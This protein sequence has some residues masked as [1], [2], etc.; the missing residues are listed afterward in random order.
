MSDEEFDSF[1]DDLADVIPDAL[2]TDTYLSQLEELKL[3]TSKENAK[4]YYVFEW[5]VIQEG[6]YEG[7]TFSEMYRKATLEEYQKAEK[8]EQREIREARRK[9]L[10]RLISLGVPENEIATVKPSSLVGK[11]AH[12]TVTVKPRT[13]GPGFAIWVQ[14]VEL[15]DLTKE[16][17]ELNF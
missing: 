5:E 10:A 16:T 6:S 3:I 2:I 13:K 14:S 11:M 8:K 15:A 7:E 12:V 17:T 1:G 4:K 9:F